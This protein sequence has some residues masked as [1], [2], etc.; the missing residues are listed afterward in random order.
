[1]QNMS[2]KEKEKEVW[3]TYPGYPWIEV[4]NLGRVKTK[5]RYVPGMN[6]SKRLMNLKPK[7]CC[8]NME[9]ISSELKIY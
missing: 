6:G 8:F 4:S 3:K 9:I 5:D 1:M 2:D 7:K